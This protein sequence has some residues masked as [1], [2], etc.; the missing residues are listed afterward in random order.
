M[1]TDDKRAAAEAQLVRRRL[2]CKQR[3]PA[4]DQTEVLSSA[5]TGRAQA[6]G[7][8]KAPAGSAAAWGA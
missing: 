4:Y 1:F 7:S 8:S 5:P 3:P 6:T 2:R